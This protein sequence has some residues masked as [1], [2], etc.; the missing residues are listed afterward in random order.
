MDQDTRS[1]EKADQ[2]KGYKK[3]LVWQKANEMVILTYAL[4]KSFPRDEVYGLTSQLRRAAVSV[5]ANIV[6]GSARQGKKELKNFCNI[7]LGSLAETEYLIDLAY[8]LHYFDGQG[9]ADLQGL[10]QETGNLLWCFYQSL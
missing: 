4:T 10:R 7:A 2:I 3:L 1:P 6:E 8:T 5:A 9:H